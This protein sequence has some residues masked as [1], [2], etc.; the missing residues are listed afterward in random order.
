[1]ISILMND[2]EDEIRRKLLRKAHGSKLRQGRNVKKDEKNEFIKFLNVET[3]S[4][5]T[6]II[7]YSCLSPLADLEENESSVGRR[8]VL[9]STPLHCPSPHSLH[10]TWVKGWS[11]SRQHRLEIK[12]V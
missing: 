4:E 10:S 7:F 1:M 5:D 9:A 2:S 11:Q 8:R 6:E 12:Q 3:G